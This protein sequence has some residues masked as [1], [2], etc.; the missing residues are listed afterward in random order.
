MTTAIRPRGGLA[1]VVGVLLLPGACTDSGATASETTDRDP[2]E[3]G[4][5]LVIPAPDWEPIDPVEAGFDPFALAELVEAAE[6]SGSHCLAV[7]RHGRLVGEWNFGDWTS[8][9]TT[10]FFSATK[11]MASTL[12]GIAQDEGRLDIDDRASDYITEWRGTPSEDVTIRDLLSNDSGRYWTFDS[13]YRQMPAAPS[14]T[15]FAVALG[16][17]FPPDV[18]WQYNNAS[19]QTLEAVLEAALDEDPVDFA[20]TRLVEPL[21]MTGTWRTDASGNLQTY[22]GFDGSCGDAL[23][24]G[25]MALAGGSWGDEQ[26]VSPAW[27]DEAT[28]RPSQS[29]NAAYGFL[30]WRN[31]DGGWQNVATGEAGFGPYWP[32]VPEDAYAALGLGGQTVAVQPS[33]GV[34]LA[35][36]APVN[37]LGTTTAPVELLG[38]VADAVVDD[39]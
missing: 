38:L 37:T 12:V 5:E 20:R 35:R 21:G 39:G 33:S 3:T 23:R 18:R 14:N 27:L 10:L 26:I 30:W 36:L 15:D 24:F 13:D 17:Q 22:M 1:A 6:A 11:S 25:N 2:R 8:A 7:T 19:I 9:D 32:G 34:V 31:A 28:G 4:P 16:Q 29:L